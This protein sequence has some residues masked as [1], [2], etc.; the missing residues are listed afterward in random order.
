MKSLTMIRGEE[1]PRQQGARALASPVPWKGTCGI[2]QGELPA[3]P[4][5][6]ESLTPACWVFVGS[7]D[8]LSER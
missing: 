8:L 4:R 5:Q 7:F 1:R 6:G 2:R 3:A